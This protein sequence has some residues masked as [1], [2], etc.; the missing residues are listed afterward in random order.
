MVERGGAPSSSQDV[1]APLPIPVRS[2][3]AGI[4]APARKMMHL[5][6]MPRL[7]MLLPVGH[8]FHSHVNSGEEMLCSHYPGEEGEAWRG[9]ATPAPPLVSAAAETGVGLLGLV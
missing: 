2:S 7:P 1:P 5:C 9:E 4:S 8:S 6:N 3:V